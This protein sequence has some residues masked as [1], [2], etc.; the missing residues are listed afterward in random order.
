LRGELARA[1][2]AEA[3]LCCLGWAD[4]GLLELAASKMGAL[5]VYVPAPRLP[6][7]AQ[8]RQWIE[9][10]EQRLGLE[11]A[12]CPESGFSSENE[13]LVARLEGSELASREETRPPTLLVGR[14]WP[15]QV[16]LV[17]ETVMEWLPQTPGPIGIIAPEDSPTAIA[18][19]EALEMAGVTVEHPP[20]KREPAAHLLI[21]EQVARYHLAGQD[22]EELIEVVKLLWLQG[23]TAL[24]PERVRDLLD[25]AFRVAQS[26][27]ARI[28]AQAQPHRRD[29]AWSAVCELVDALGKWEGEFEPAALREKWEAMLR[30][31]RLPAD[32]LAWPGQP[33]QGG[34]AFM[35][36]LAGQV[37]AQRRETPAPDYAMLAPVVVTT[38]AGAVHQTWER[39]IFLDSN[40]HVWP[41]SGQ[42]RFPRVVEEARFLDLVEH[43]RGAIAF[44][45]VL[46]EHTDAGEHAQPNE[47]VLRALMESAGDRFAPDVWAASARSFPPVAPPPLEEPERAHLALVA[48]SRQNGTMPFDRYHFNFHETKL[49]PGAWSATEL[50][51][52]VT[53]PATFALQELFGAAA[54]EPFA[55]GEGA[56]VGNRTHRWLGNILR[57][58]DAFTAPAPAA[59]D[60]ASLAR[61]LAGARRELEE[62]Y[63][64]ENLAMPL[65]WES[66][67]RKTQWATRRCLREVRPWLDT[68]YCA[69]EQS[70]AVRVQTAGGALLLKGRIDLV[71]SDRAGF[72]DAA[73]RMFDFK[74]GRGAAPTLATLEKGKGA[75][76]AAYYLMARE[77]GAAEAAVGIIKPEEQSHEVFGDEAVLR[78]RFAVLA[79]LWRNLRFGQRG[80][81]LAEY[82]ECETLPMA[83]VPIAVEI[84]EQKAAL[85]LLA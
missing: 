61:E 6:A 68:P 29:A 30:A 76:F 27:N 47:W 2:A 10:V 33:L 54:R 34:R 85:H 18:V 78:A 64:A 69:M 26:R 73:V 24:E 12:T 77:A 50:D 44:A 63:G 15:D 35:E 66:C 59:G 41:V 58:R 28:L 43:C 62:W 38:F 52:A 4:L 49:E 37:A 19:A 13:A 16:R 48:G 83:T 45:G 32:S 75:Q 70:L 74:T 11:R 20:R 79:E 84:L 40:E 14:E 71:I 23:W 55:R 25:H 31:L 5:E 17:C 60:E 82:G 8:Q 21:L 53:C 46:L 51:K 65:W 22:V 81:F 67:L 57:L 56:A 1:P 39:L 36:W 9:A 80:P 3:R 42:E 72:R 7:D